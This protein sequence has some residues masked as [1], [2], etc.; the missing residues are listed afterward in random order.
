M[1]WA[2]AAAGAVAACFLQTSRKAA[3]GTVFFKEP[4]LNFFHVSTLSSGLLVYV[5]LRKENTVKRL[6]IWCVFSKRIACFLMSC[7]DL[8]FIRKPT[9]KEVTMYLYPL[10]M[11]ALA[12]LGSQELSWF[13]SQCTS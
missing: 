13:R 2:A 5:D 1:T 7:G 11:Q 10:A 3:E 4:A 8:Y 12:E 9:P 6:Q